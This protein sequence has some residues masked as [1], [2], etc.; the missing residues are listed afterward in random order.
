MS[1]DHSDEIGW[2]AEA[3]RVYLDESTIFPRLVRSDRR[4]DMIVG[5]RKWKDANREETRAIDMRRYHR[6]RFKVLS[7]RWFTK[8][9]A[10]PRF[11]RRK[12][13]AA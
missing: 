8:T 9:V 11:R 1:I 5:S 12:A 2:P 13:V 10:F 7:L 3:T 6:W 4:E